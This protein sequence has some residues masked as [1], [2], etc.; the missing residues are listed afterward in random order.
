MTALSSAFPSKWLKH[1]DL[2]G[3]ARKF[4]M[5]HVENIEIGFGAN[6]E[7]KPV[8]FFEGTDKGLV[9]N[10]TNANAIIEAYGDEMDNF[11][12]KELILVPTCTEFQ[13]KSHDVIRVR[14]PK[15]GD[16]TARPVDA[17]APV[18]AA[19]ADDDLGDDIPF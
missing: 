14:A 15:P 19:A 16:K 1:G 13:G 4:L 9:L 6:K 2:G 10:R 18:E 12:G 17:V 3:K 8:L 7:T 5:S 11:A